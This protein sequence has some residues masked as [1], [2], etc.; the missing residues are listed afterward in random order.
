LELVAE[1]GWRI[2]PEY[3]YDPVSGVWRHHSRLSG[4]HHAGVTKPSVENIDWNT[5]I[6]TPLSAPDRQP[7]LLNCD[8]AL[9][10]ARYTLL[11]TKDQ[12]NVI[13]VQL[14]DPFESLRWFM[15]PG[16][17]RDLLRLMG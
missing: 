14:P 8:M 16:E 6:N 15:Q 17:A 13:D 5:L 1:F 10:E 4:G 9:A 2:L 7:L 11:S 12:A 3:Q